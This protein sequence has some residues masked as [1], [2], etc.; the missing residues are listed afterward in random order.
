MTWPLSGPLRSPP[1]LAACTVKV[2]DQ[3][4]SGDIVH[5]VIVSTISESLKCVNIPAQVIWA[6]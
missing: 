3:L 5:P 1:Q 4:V 6:R 2:S